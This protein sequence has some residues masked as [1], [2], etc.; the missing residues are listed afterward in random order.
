MNEHSLKTL[1]N[2]ITINKVATSGHCVQDRM[3]LKA[4][5]KSLEVMIDKVKDKYSR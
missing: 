5:I 3:D 4:Y 1:P 2:K